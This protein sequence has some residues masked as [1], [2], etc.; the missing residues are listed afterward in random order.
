MQLHR[1]QEVAE[2]D[3][4]NGPLTSKKDETYTSN[5]RFM[6]LHS[7]GKEPLM[8]VFASHL[9]HPHYLVHADATRERPGT[10]RNGGYAGPLLFRCITCWVMGFHN[11]LDDEGS[12]H[13]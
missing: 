10:K 9:Q 5:K 12:Q 6:R 11:V 1:D 2:W 8:L 7:L 13:I 4:L 3:I